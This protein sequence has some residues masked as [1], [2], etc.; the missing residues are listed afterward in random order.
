MF[1]GQN[2]SDLDSFLFSISKKEKPGRDEKWNNFNDFAPF[3]CSTFSFWYEKI[4]QSQ[5]PFFETFAY[6]FWMSSTDGA[7][8]NRGVFFL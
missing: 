8:F 7:F 3:F 2:N 6:L 4:A 5:L 1:F